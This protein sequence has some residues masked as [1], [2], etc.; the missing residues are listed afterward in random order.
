[1]SP[2]RPAIEGDPDSHPDGDVAFLPQ[3]AHFAFGRRL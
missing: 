2:F 1:M 3:G